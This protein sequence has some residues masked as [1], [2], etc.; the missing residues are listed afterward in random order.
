MFLVFLH[1]I[2][3]SSMH[4]L[5]KIFEELIQ[6]NATVYLTLAMVMAWVKAPLTPEY[7]PYRRA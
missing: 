7:K 4:L 2:L 3:F 1:T 6:C 5:E